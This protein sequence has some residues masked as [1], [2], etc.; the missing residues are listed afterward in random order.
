MND[1]T[2]LTNNRQGIEA[3]GEQDE[4]LD[5]VKIEPDGVSTWAIE[6]GRGP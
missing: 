3:Q 4:M 1:K 6:N 2:V 5:G